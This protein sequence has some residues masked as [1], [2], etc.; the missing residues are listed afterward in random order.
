[1]TRNLILLTMYAVAMA[2]LESAVVV[3]L[4]Q[5]YYPENPQQ[6]FPL[7]FLTRIDMFVELGREAATVIMILTVALL[8]ERSSKTRCFAAFVYVFG[9]W[10]IFYYLWLKV[11]IGWPVTWL[12]W[13]VLFL[14]PWVWL[15][16]WICP[17]LIAGVFIMWG[18]WVLL[19]ANDIAFNTGSLAVFVVGAVLGVAAF[20]QPAVP[21][22]LEQGVDGMSHYEPTGFWWWLFAP[23]FALIAL[24]LGM[25][26]R[27]RR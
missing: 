4:R 15:G 27:S 24:G 11:M 18:A 5:L 16:P 23:S 13:D 8:A 21:V 7:R 9:V 10:D 20:L 12:E 26:L 22:L 3:Y 17:A 6:M 14:I 25:T 1:M 2:L 19:S